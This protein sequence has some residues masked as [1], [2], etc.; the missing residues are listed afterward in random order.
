M[1]HFFLLIL[2]LC[3]MGAGYPG[4]SYETKPLYA[5]DK[6]G[7][8]FAKKNNLKF[9]NSALGSYLTGSEVCVWSL[10]FISRNAMTIDEARP[11]VKSLTLKVL[12]KIKQDPLFAAYLEKGK[13]FITTALGPD[14]VGF[15][16]A[17]WDSEVNRPLYPYLAQIRLAEGKIFYHYADPKT[18]ALQDPI[19]ESIDSFQK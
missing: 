19:I 15:R 8:D 14:A 7:K 18:Q 17:F 9:L 6:L 1:K 3:L 2:S 4:P 5:L 12:E 13:G 16:L 10:N 11:M